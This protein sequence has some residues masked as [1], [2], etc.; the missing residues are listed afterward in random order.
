MQHCNHIRI[1]LQKLN[2]FKGNSSSNYPVHDMSLVLTA[3]LSS[4]EGSSYL[5][6][7]GVPR[8]QHV[9]KVTCRKSRNYSIPK[10][11]NSQLPGSEVSGTQWP[12]LA[13]RHARHRWEPSSLFF[14]EMPYVPAP[15]S[16]WLTCFVIWER[17]M[18]IRYITLDV[19]QA[20]CKPITSNQSWKINVACNFM[21][22]SMA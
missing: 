20:H 19:L 14:S 1:K 4:T 15:V 3:E 13:P 5:Y 12:L 6:P 9:L 16:F 18:I 22:I 10:I 7:L 21:C 2:Q 8:I 11:L 17:R